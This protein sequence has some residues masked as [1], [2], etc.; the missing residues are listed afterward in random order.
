M[1]LRVGEDEDGDEGEGV[2]SSSHCDPH[3]HLNAKQL[4]SRLAF[5]FDR[6]KKMKQIF[7]IYHVFSVVF[8]LIIDE[9]KYF[10]IV[11]INSTG[12]FIFDVSLSTFSLFS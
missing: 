11:R 4:L 8:F 2:D 12:K 1:R 3:P 10:F 5:L 6:Q 9:I 7:L